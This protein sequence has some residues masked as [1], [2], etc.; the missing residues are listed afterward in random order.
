MG[1]FYHTP[2]YQGDGLMFFAGGS[3]AMPARSLPTANPTQVSRQAIPASA[4]YAFLP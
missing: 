4:K 1:G 3:E 2:L